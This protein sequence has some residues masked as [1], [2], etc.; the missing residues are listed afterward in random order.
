M[1]GLYAITIVFLVYA[2]G[3]IIATKTKVIISSLFVASIFFAVAFWN[4]LPATIFEDSALQ[5][6]ADVAVGILLVHMGTSISVRNLISEWKT[7]II[8]FC[9]SIAIVVGIYFLAGIFIDRD[10]VLMGAPVLGGGVVA[11]LVMAEEMAKSAGADVVA[12]GSLLLVIHGVVGFPLASWLCSKEAKRIRTEIRGG[13]IVL[14]AE[15]EVEKNSRGIRIFP[16]MPEKYNSGNMM[17]AKAALV[18]CLASWLSNLTGGN[19]NMLVICLLLG[20]LFRELGFLDENPLTKGSAF[21]LVMGA[22]LVNVFAS[23][24]DTTPSMIVTMLKPL[25]IVVIIGLAGCALVSIL[26]GKIFKQSWYMSFA[27]GVS[28]LFGFPG[29]FIVPN[30]VA[31]SI[32]ETEEEKKIILQNIMPKMIIAGMVSVSIMSVVIAGI[33]VKLV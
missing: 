6:L 17:I 31:N 29:T 8:V 20:V 12:F 4:G 15:Q 30:E 28:A 16:E 1:N 14:A 5:A 32:G 23:L 11:F 9:S 19:V 21:T 26:V 10:F 24:A 25:V 13:N 22:V 33:I 7:V 3:D 2:V 18:A 27:L